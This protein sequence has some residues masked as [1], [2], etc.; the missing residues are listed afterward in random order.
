VQGLVMAV[1]W[2]FC[3]AAG[4]ICSAACGNDKPSTEAPSA[5]SGRR[6]SALL[7]LMS[8]GLAFVFQYALAPV[9]GNE[10]N[11]IQAIPYAGPY[12]FDAWQQGCTVSEEEIVAK[13]YSQEIVHQLEASCRGNNGVYRVSGATFLVFILLALAAKCKPTFN[14]EAWPAKYALFLF[15][16]AG[17]IFIPNQPMNSPFYMQLSRACAAIF[18][19]IQQVIFIDIG[20]NW[21]ESWVTKSNHAEAEETGSGRKW[22][23]AILASC[24]LLFAASLT[25]IGFMF[26]YFAGDGCTANKWFIS[27]TLILNILVLI[28]QLSGEVASLLTSAVIGAYGSY[29]CYSA[30]TRSPLAVCN[31]QLGESN[32]FGI[33]VGVAMT[34][35]SLTWT[36]YSHTAAESL[37]SDTAASAVLVQN[38]SS[39]DEERGSSHSELKGVVTGSAN[40]AEIGIAVAE[41]VANDLPGP[42]WKI[43]VVLAFTC[44]WY[45]MVLTGWGSV[46]ASGTPANPQ[47]DNVSVWIVIASQ[48]CMYLIYT[49]TLVAPRLFPDREF[50]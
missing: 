2:C 47:A 11:K 30:V 13:G 18:V 14:R 21:N 40:H 3:S 5:A 33:V 38:S 41:G 29:L 42:T 9:F 45:A 15:L 32:V 34:I 46:D 10:S 17:T 6:R 23:A 44:A 39:G 27:V 37:S 31:P 24:G 8:V 26:G 48:W 25:L 7:L 43:N 19:I 22:L 20:Y 50:S 36:G 1:S 4:S 28:I 49:W 16:V 12:I 35:I